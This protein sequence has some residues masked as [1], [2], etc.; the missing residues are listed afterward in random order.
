M[1]STNRRFIVAYVLLVCGPLAALAG[2]LKV[3]R[4]LTAPPSIDGVWK[5]DVNPG[6]PAADPCDQAVSALLDSPIVVSQSGKHLEITFKGASHGAVPAELEGRDF[7]ASLRPSA[8]TSAQLV[9]LVASVDLKSE[10]RALTGSLAVT[11]CASCAPLEF[12][13]VR[14]PRSQSGAA[15]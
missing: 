7:R 1:W 5:V 15:R 12:R 9:K 3:G 8:C 14:Q 6:T 11:N 13:A 2:V 4:S 10:P